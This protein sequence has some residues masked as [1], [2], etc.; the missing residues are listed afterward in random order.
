MDGRAQRLLGESWAEMLGEEFDKTYFKNLGKLV[1]NH[2]KKVKVYPDRQN[3]F[4]AFRLT[5]FNKVRV[6]IVGQD[7]YHNGHAHG[8]SFSTHKNYC[9]QSLK[10]IFKEI[11]ND[12]G[13]PVGSPNLERWAKQGVFLLNTV[14]TVVEGQPNSHKGIGWEEFTGKALNLLSHSP[15]PTVFM[16]WGK[17][18]QKLKTLIHPDNHLILEA[19]HPSPFSVHEGFFGCKHFSQCNDFLKSHNLKPIDWS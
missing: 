7:P 12:M 4:K 17:R 15:V 3:V 1:A 8:L 11:Q 19:P 13:Y 5:P 6:V 10:N 16:L 9:P 14:L 18:A 2:R